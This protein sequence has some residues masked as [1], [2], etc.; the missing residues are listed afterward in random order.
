MDVIF[1]FLK[2]PFPAPPPKKSYEIYPV[3][4]PGVKNIRFT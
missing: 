2:K 4:H 3:N 1:Q